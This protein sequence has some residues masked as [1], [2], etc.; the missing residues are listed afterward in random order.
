MITGSR[1]TEDSGRDGYAYYLLESSGYND[2]EKSDINHK[3]SNSS[4]DEIE[5]IIQDLLLNQVDTW[6]NYRLKDINRR[7]DLKC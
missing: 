1:D 2:M 7:L 4:P 5:E 3:I 6:N